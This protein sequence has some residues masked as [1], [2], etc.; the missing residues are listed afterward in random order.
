MEASV[1]S[2][3]KTEGRIR[4]EVLE[5]GDEGYEAARRV[6]NATVDKRPA[7]IVRCQGAA[8]V[9]QAVQYARDDDLELAVR[10]GG[11][12]FAGKSVSDGGVMIDLSAMRAVRVSPDGS[13]VRVQGGATWADVDHETQAHGLATNG[14]LISHTG[15]AGLTLGGGIGWLS[16]KHGLSCDNLV[17]ADVVTAAGELVHASESENPDLFWGLRGGSG[18]FG[19]VTEFEFRLHPVGPEVLGGFIIHP[20]AA[21]ADGLRF[22]REFT[23]NAP[24]EVACYALFGTIPPEPPFPAEHQGKTGFFLAAGY[25]G[26]VD[27][28]ED[29]LRELRAFG[30]PIVDAIQP[31]PYTALQK[32][33][34]AAQM[35]GNRW[36]GK[37][38]FW[39]EM[40]DDAIDTLVAGVDPLSGP[41]TMVFFEPMGGAIGRVPAAATAFPHREAPYNFGITAGW[42]DDDDDEQ[43]IAWARDL[44]TSLEQYGAGVYVNYANED[45][46]HRRGEA[47]GENYDRLVEVKKKWDPNNLF[48]L[49]MNIPPS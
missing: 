16:R 9:S 45:E 36:Y 14:G 10:G 46:A 35:P 17:A 5:P 2:S 22:Y 7:V 4:G 33:F 41:L 38:G 15:V 39:K 43:N 18:N 34:D 47:Y 21:A 32:S 19:V 8:D 25:M 27:D 37:S 29:A 6:W 44:Y 31:L 42:I 30:D 24:D 49:N 40:S 28:G 3:L 20:V 26:P 12:S 48:R 11:H 1:E 23:E 13:T